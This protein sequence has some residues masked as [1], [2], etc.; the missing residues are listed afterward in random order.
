M[1]ILVCVKKRTTRQNAVKSQSAQ[2]SLDFVSTYYNFLSLHN[3]NQ[4]V[5]FVVFLLGQWA[6]EVKQRLL[7]TACHWLNMVRSCQ[8]F[9]QRIVFCPTL[10][11][12]KNKKATTKGFKH[13]KQR[14][15]FQ[16]SINR[17]G[18]GQFRNQSSKLSISTRTTCCMG[19]IAVHWFLHLHLFSF[20]L[21]LQ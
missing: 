4:R 5:L 12:K 9:N 19:K 13:E 21:L 17:F 6:H 16:L 14:N 2:M 10:E 11:R 1:Y 20:I 15:V 18:T 3:L 7:V 8:Q